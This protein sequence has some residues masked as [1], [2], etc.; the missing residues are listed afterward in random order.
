MTTA[1]PARRPWNPW[2]A[3]W[4]AGGAGP[5]WSLAKNSPPAGPRQPCSCRGCIPGVPPRPRGNCGALGPP[6]PHGPRRPRSPPRSPAQSPCSP[7]QPPEAP[8]SPRQAAGE[9]ASPGGK[10]L[11]SSRGFVPRAATLCGRWPVSVAP[12]GHSFTGSG[13]A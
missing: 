1:T 8:H 5:V 12:G 4:T 7:S 6:R 2:L 13:S 10:V 9:G 11:K 3:E